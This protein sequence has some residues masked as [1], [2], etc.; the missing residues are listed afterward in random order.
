MK[1]PSVGET[2][3]SISLYEISGDVETV[4]DS[5]KFEGILSYCVHVVQHNTEVINFL[6]VTNKSK[7]I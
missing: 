3:Y 6:T 2:N 1:Y 5:F 7:R 4:V